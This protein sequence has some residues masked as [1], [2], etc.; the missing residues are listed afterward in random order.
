[1]PEEPGDDHGE[2]EV[3]ETL[4]DYKL[5]E[6]LGE[7]GMARVYRGVKVGAPETEVAL[8]LIKEEFSSKEDFRRRFERETR[9]CEGLTHPNIVG[10]EG[11]GE[12]D[13][14]LFLALEFVGGQLLTEK[15]SPDGLDLNEVL[16]YLEGLV[17]G[18]NYAH[19]Q[20]VVHRDLKPDNV[21]V[22][23]DGEVKIMDFGLAR[24]QD[25]DKVTKTGDAMGTP[26]YFP[27][28]QITGAEPSA[29]ADQYSLGVMLYELLTGSR[30]FN[31]ANPL[32]LLFQ[33]LSEQPPDPLEK[34]P[35]LNPVCASI[36]LRMLEKSPENRFTS[37]SVMLEGM[38]AVAR[39]EEW[40]LPLLETV[41]E[42]QESVKVE[43]SPSEGPADDEATQ[44]F[45]VERNSP[46]G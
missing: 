45:Q 24:T 15:L 32:K 21:M 27:P 42:T 37:L 40:S 30:P 4:G 5:L 12:E 13:G 28:E 35:D 22:T 8:K 46:E 31:E 36:V 26:S 1:M 19:G 2:S 39:G 11:W 9:V 34:K 6:F 41:A 43:I 7:G 23:A 20:G 16:G 14:R 29:A 17:A 3:G 10:L 38:R 33:H 25:G 44:G 18:L